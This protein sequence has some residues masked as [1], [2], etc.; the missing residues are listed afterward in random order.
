MTEAFGPVLVESPAYPWA[1]SHYYEQELGTPIT[2]RFL[3]FERMIPQDGLRE[4][5]LQ[6][7]RIEQE[8][9]NADR[10]TVNI[11][12]G[13]VTTAKVVLASTKDYAHRIY[14]GG[15]IF[16]EVTLYYMHNAY[17]G[18]AFAYQDYLAPEVT[19]LFLEVRE[20]LRRK[21]TAQKA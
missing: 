6:A 10:R 2:R 12:P 7:M 18:C 9:A 17:H 21:A 8:L 20:G 1:H 3:F 19:A 16:A 13:Y 15:G 4:I 11:D 14:I 5:K